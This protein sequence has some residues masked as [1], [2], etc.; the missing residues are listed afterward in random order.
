MYKHDSILELK[1]NLSVGDELFF[2]GK[3][4][5]ITEIYPF[6]DYDYVKIAFDDNSSLALSV[7]DKVWHNDD[8]KTIVYITETFPDKYFNK[9]KIL[10]DNGTSNTFCCSKR[11]SISK[12]NK[13]SYKDFFDDRIKTITKTAD[14]LLVGDE[15]LREGILK[16]KTIIDINHTY[17]K[18][19][20]FQIGLLFDDSDT[21]DF[22]W[23]NWDKE[24]TVLDDYKPEAH[25]Q[26]T[27]TNKNTEITKITYTFNK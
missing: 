2:N 13:F 7:G 9:C 21:D 26:K 14:Q 27:I 25:P 6:V 4:K 8:I 15:I 12:D 17:I 10:F 11:N 22:K 5:T 19:Y 23:F 20:I 16:I 24:F 18:D 3:T 1:N